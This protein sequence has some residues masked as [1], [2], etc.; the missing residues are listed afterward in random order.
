MRVGWRSSLRRDGEREGE[1]GLPGVED[2]GPFVPASPSPTS[3]TP[4][5]S[6]PGAL[7]KWRPLAMNAIERSGLWWLGGITPSN[8]GDE[9]ALCRLDARL[10]TDDRRLGDSSALP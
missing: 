9:A 2:S 4:S 5:P 3:P 6:P 7:R 8:R 1:P 10:P